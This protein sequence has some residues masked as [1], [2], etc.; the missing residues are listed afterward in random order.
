MSVIELAPLLAAFFNASLAI[1]V[2]SRDSNSRLNQVFLL[3]GMALAI[4]NFGAFMMFRVDAAEEAYF[5]A[6]ALHFGV[7]FIPVSV[8]HLTL[9]ITGSRVNRWIVVPYVTALIL[10]GTNFSDLFIS[11]VHQSGFAWFAEP[12]LAYFVYATLFPFH[13][14]PAL[15]L[16]IRRSKACASHE[17]R[18]YTNLIVANGGLLIFG[19]HDLLPIFGLGKYPFTDINVFPWGTLM[20]AFYGLFVGYSVLQDRL[21]DVR[22]TLGRQA[23]MIVRLLFLIGFSVALLLVAAIIKPNS[24]NAYSFVSAGVVIVLSAVITGRFFPKLLGV[25][26]EYLEQ[27]ILG[28]RFEHQERIEDYTRRLPYYTNIDDLLAGLQELLAESLKIS[29]FH[30]VALD[31]RS[32]LKDLDFRYP[33]E[34]ST[35]FDSNKI[36]AFFDHFTKNPVPSLDLTLLRNEMRNNASQSTDLTTSMIYAEEAEFCFPLYA[37]KKPFGLLF[38]SRKEDNAAFTS[39]DIELCE[40]L[41]R[42]LALVLDHLRLK[43]QVA[44]TEQW[45]SLAAMSRGLAHDIN[46]LLTPVSTYFQSL[47]SAD[48]PTGQDELVDVCSR[49]TV[50]IEGYVRASLFFSKN[51]RPKLGLHRVTDIL[52]SAKMNVRGQMAEFSVRVLTEAESDLK[53]NADRSLLERLVTN[54]L[55]NA[56]DASVSGERVVVRA[57][58]IRNPGRKLNTVR[59]S[60]IDEGEGIAEEH[61]Q[62]VIEPYFSTKTSGDGKRGFGLGLAI[63][64]RLA[65]LHGGVLSIDSTL[66]HG[67]TVLVDLPQDG[68]ANA[69]QPSSREH[70]LT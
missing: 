60:V 52:E 19:G 61:V 16:L 27:R 23:A 38:F 20:A 35:M 5:W 43:S 68:P 18:R 70:A 36:G 57:G 17:R 25:G 3:W 32:Q 12:G 65:H 49:N 69:P 42:N 41:T 26:S 14:I 66:G 47:E 30:L 7:I 50:K 54:L 53:I 4:W 34:S 59:V 62:R 24:F 51:M 22:V 29:R 58:V 13:T 45:E 15:V 6:R 56:I 39:L 1:F 10:S 31:A 37:Q 44:L 55:S 9:L 63:C 48:I 67:T 28:D 46:N 8:L 33:T 21:L 2:I 40:R 64:Q 11:G